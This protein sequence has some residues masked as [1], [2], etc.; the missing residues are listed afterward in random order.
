MNL[1]LTVIDRQVYNVL[2]FLGDIGGLAEALIYIFSFIL[3][4]LNYEKFTTM[5]N[6]HLYRTREKPT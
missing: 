5:L 3:A 2:D 1:D 6:R 4:I